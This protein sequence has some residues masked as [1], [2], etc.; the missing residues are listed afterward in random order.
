[1]DC[2]KENGYKILK[3]FRTAIIGIAMIAV[4]Y[5]LGTLEFMQ[6]LLDLYAENT[7]WTDFLFF[8]RSIE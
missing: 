4:P 7:G 5:L 1:M 2:N 6:E 3:K 8:E